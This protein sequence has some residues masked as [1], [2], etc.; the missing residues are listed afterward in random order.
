[1]EIEGLIDKA[2]WENIPCCCTKGDVVNSFPLIKCEHCRCQKCWDSVP[3]EDFTISENLLDEDGAVIEKQ[4]KTVSKIK[5]VRG[6]IEDVVGWT[7]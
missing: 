1:M 3:K 6:N 5:L 7:W 4:A 2:L